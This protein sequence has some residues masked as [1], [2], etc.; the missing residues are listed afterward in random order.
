[1]YA[2][3]V[4]RSGQIFLREDGYMKNHAFWSSRPLQSPSLKEQ[5][6]KRRMSER[7]KTNTQYPLSTVWRASR[8]DKKKMQSLLWRMMCVQKWKKRQ[9]THSM[10][11]CEELWCLH[12]Y[13]S[14]LASCQKMHIV[15]DSSA[16]C[17]LQH[18]SRHLTQREYADHG[19][20]MQTF[21]Q[22]SWKGKTNKKRSYKNELLTLTT[23]T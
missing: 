19:S 3:V 15:F 1:M 17:F 2:Q 22:G 8:N 12:A 16:T 11:C 18:A 9:K 7:R 6:K 10:P 13:K 20:K 21:S 14:I 4:F 5:Q 23:A